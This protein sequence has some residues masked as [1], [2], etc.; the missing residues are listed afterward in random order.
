MK[1]DHTPQP[2]TTNSL[3][4]PRGRRL[5]TVKMLA[6]LGITILAA[7]I[8][9]YRIDEIPPG[10]MYDP[11][12]YGVDALQILAGERPIFFPTN[13]GREALFSYLVALYIA[14]F[15]A[16]PYA[17]YV[18]SALVGTATVP[19]V[20]LLVEELFSGENG[21]LRKYGGLLAAAVLAVSH[22]HL[23]WSRFGV[24][25][26]LV[27]LVSALTFFFLWRGLRTG[28]RRHMVASGFF[29]GV[30]A[31]TYQAARL[32]PVLVV[33][34]FLYVAVTRH[35]L[36]R[37]DLVNLG[38]VSLVALIVFAPLG[39]YFITH[40]GSFLQR[41]EQASVVGGDQGLADNLKAIGKGVV[42]TVLS[43]YVQ[44]DSVPTTNLPGRP[45][46]NPFLCVLFTLGVVASLLRIGRAR[47]LFLL[48][49]LVVLMIPAVLSTYGPV[50]KRAIGTLPAVMA[51]IALGALAPLDRLWLWAAGRRSAWAHAVPV[52]LGICIFVGLFYSAARTWRDYFVL[53]ATD[54]DLFTHFEAGPTAIGQY[55]RDLSAETVLYVSPIDPDHPAIVYN[56]QR[57]PGIR[58][59]DGRACLVLPEET[60][61]ETIYVIVPGEDATS[62]DALRI[63]FPQGDIVAEGPLHY[64]QPYFLAYQVP[65]DSTPQISPSHPLEATWGDRLKLLGYDLDEDVYRP[66]DTIHLTLYLQ[67]LEEMGVDYTLFVHL[68]GPENPATGSSLWGQDDSEPCRRSYPT[69]VWRPGEILRDK[70]AIPIPSEAETGNY[71]VRVGFYLLETLTRLPAVD[72]A[73]LPVPDDSVLL[74]PVHVQSRSSGSGGLQAD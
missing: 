27:P 51:L 43:F 29:L 65:P 5:L 60:E 12:Y 49:W 68:L 16:A 19:A 71:E 25:A 22:W 37:S 33:L 59:F 61:A 42:D 45:T 2:Q 17:M 11:A 58:G 32:F 66:G 46:L 18:T 36:T 34:A 35:K 72:A 62:L 15:G 48:T 44:G 69:S 30:G 1:L 10:N 13:F 20:Y 63:A 55:A 39:A 50:A 67:A 26:V 74:A 23:H 4:G 47:F 21:L 7:C 6:L 53:W 56:A 41:V 57:R 52:F 3:P 70:Y 54:P 73:G 31:Y 64:N 28:S 8:R 14:F 9:L 38:I 24:R 40:P